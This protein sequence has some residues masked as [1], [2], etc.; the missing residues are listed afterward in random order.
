VLVARV[1]PLG[2]EREVE[3]EAGGEAR[4]LLEQGADDLV[5]GAR[6]GGRLE[7]DERARLEHLPGG[8]GR[9]LDRGEVGAIGL[10]QRGRHADDRDVRSAVTGR[11]GDVRGR[12]ETPRDHGRD[13]GVGQVID[14]RAADVERVDGGLPHVEAGDAQPGPDRLLRERQAHVAKPDDH[15]VHGND[16]LLLRR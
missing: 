8:L 15:H 6:V 16:L 4:Q 10:R 13:V 3:V 1:D 2:R 14:M 12:P 9:G 5:G 7:D 11:L